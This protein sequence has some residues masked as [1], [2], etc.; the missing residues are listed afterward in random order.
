MTDER[1]PVGHV[2][3]SLDGLQGSLLIRVQHMLDMI[4]V[5]LCGIE[6]VSSTDYD[7]FKPAFFRLDTAQNHRFSRDAA[8]D[9]ASRWILRTS[10]RDV[11]ESVG[12]YLEKCRRVLALVRAAAGRGQILGEDFLRVTGYEARRFHRLGL[13]DKLKVL[14]D[15]FDLKPSL[16]NQI[17][18]INRVRNCLVHRDGLVTTADLADEGNLVLRWRVLELYAKQE[19]GSE[20][21]IEGPTVV[22][23]GSSIIVKS[24]DRS[25]EFRKGERIE[26]PYSEI[27]ATFVTVMLFAMEITTEIQRLTNSLPA[28]EVAHRIE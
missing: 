10:F 2:N 12:W 5:T 28:P 18:S 25:R 14:R 23:G 1:Q 15:E 26:L 3:I 13:P 17:L 11:I 8:A 4:A 24:I 21:A 16:A 19:D 6:R 20:S 27:T 7:D 9:A 22:R